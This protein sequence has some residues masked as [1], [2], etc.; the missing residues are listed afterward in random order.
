MTMGFRKASNRRLTLATVPRESS[1]AD[2]LLDN[3]RQ[4]IRL[5]LVDDNPRNPRSQVDENT[6]GELATSIAEHGLLQAPV[7]RRHPDNP[8]RYMV[9]LGARRIAAHRLL[10]REEIEVIV[11]RLDDHQAFL[12]SCVENVQR[13]E[14]SPR[15]EMDMIGV[16]VDELGSQ[17]AAARALGKSPTWLSKRKRV[18]SAPAL[19]AAVERGE[20]SLDHAYDVITRSPDEETAL[21]Q[22]EQVRIGRQSQGMTRGKLAPRPHGPER[23]LPL[24]DR[25][26]TA[27]SSTE[28]P[29]QTKILSGR[30]D[31]THEAITSDPELAV[32]SA[33]N[34]SSQGQAA[35]SYSSTEDD[36]IVLKTLAT[37]QLTLDSRGR[38]SR[39]AVLRALRSDLAM[40]EGR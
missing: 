19:A 40:V 8:D 13:V 23:T 1:A 36:N 33:R 14:L 21:M 31:G 17:E 11:R 3:S 7:V 39:Q 10:G 32:I 25:N 15:E 29:H 35:D 38:A 28:T 9:V 12:A 18:L 2:R 30:N 24:S 27:E 4:M 26:V 5:D 16:L 20:I 37:V 34:S 22:L 6:L